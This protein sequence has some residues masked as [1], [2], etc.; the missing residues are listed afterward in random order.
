MTL[1]A[2]IPGTSPDTAETPDSRL[3]SDSGVTATSDQV[4]SDSPPKVAGGE[5]RDFEYQAGDLV[6]LI[7]WKVNHIVETGCKSCQS[8]LGE[9]LRD[10]R[11][12][13]VPH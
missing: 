7:L 1:V 6:N 12:S 8:E 11:L 4:T 2:T 13:S 9:L 10:W 5:S 3:E